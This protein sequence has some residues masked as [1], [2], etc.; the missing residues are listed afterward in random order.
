[1]GSFCQEPCLTSIELNKKLK[2]L[3]EKKAN[4][5]VEKYGVKFEG[6]LSIFF[7]S[8]DIESIVKHRW[9]EMRFCEKGVKISKM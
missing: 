4:E 2:H 8:T 5:N 7:S 3:F 9:V 6:P 1:M